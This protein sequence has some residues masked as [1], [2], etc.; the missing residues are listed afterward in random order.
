MKKKYLLLV[1]GIAVV[2][3][4]TALFLNSCNSSGDPVIPRISVTG[5]D[6]KPHLEDCAKNRALEHFNKALLKFEVTSCEMLGEIAVTDKSDESVSKYE[7][8][9]TFHVKLDDKPTGLVTKSADVTV[10]GTITVNSDGKKDFAPDTQFSIKNE[11][12]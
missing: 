7:G 4:G 6:F 5:E 8:E 10:K 11:A 12:N 1:I 2:A 3:I 9:G